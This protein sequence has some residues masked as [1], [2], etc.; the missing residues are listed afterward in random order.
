MK[1]TTLFPSHGTFN[2]VD[3]SK[4][5]FTA[6][7]SISCL[8]LFINADAQTLPAGFSQVLVANNIS[9]PTVMAFAPDGRIFVAQQTGQLRIIKNGSLLAQPFVS[10]SVNS[11]GERGLLGIAFDPNFNS[12][13]YIY[14]YHTLLS[15]A[16]NRITRYTA[17]GD[18]ALAGSDT[19]ILNL[20]PLSGATNHNGG[21]M[22][23]GPDGKLYVGIG[24]NATPSNSQSLAT[25][26]GK[27]IRINPDGSIPAGN[28]Y[29]TG[30]NQQRRIWSYGLRNPYT[31]TFQPGTGRL[32][33]NDVGAVT[34][35]EINDATAGGLNFGWPSSEGNS[36]DP[37][38]ADPVYAYGHGSGSGLGC[39]I[40]GGTFFNPATT[41]Y[42]TSYIGKYFYVDLCGN[43]I[44]VLTLNPSVNRANFAS[45]I[46]GSPLSIVTGPDGNLYFASRSNNA[47]YKIIYTPTGGGTTVLNPVADAYVRN[48]TFGNDNY[49]TAKSLGTK[50]SNG[51]GAT[52]HTYLRFNISSVSSSITSAKLRLYGYLNNTNVSSATVRVFNVTNNTWQ[53]NTIT[54]NNK[55]AAQ[56]AV[57]A[58]TTVNGTTKQYY[59]WDLTQHIIALKNSGATFVSL[60]LNNLT[61]T[62]STRVIYNS[63]EMTANKPQLTITTTGPRFE[64]DLIVEEEENKFIVYPNPASDHFNIKFENPSASEKLTIIDMQGKIVQQMILNGNTEESI[65]TEN[66]KDGFY[67]IY[68]DELSSAAMKIAVKK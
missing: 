22:Q 56:T 64:D 31:L 40:T 18:V 11:N 8:L 21:T 39:A 55:P 35:E 36:S 50:T 62:T 52:Y 12:N 53:E 42:P 27:V 16:N 66:M 6:V 47:V 28:P 65:S 46:A 45:G 15:G 30:G 59:E 29:N 38:H 67:L 41:N 48:G 33:V 44:D 24:E 54:F 37:T 17:N 43:W 14:L 19:V 1:K 58:S 13:H 3:L 25:Y 2:F 4:R 51:A 32:F 5:I 7:F 60:M 49:G 57:L 63:K 68:I 20:D 10:L 26:H 23:F 9:N 61:V 34:W